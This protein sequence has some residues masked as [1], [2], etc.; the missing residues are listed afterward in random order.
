VLRT[1]RPQA[2]LWEA[3]L[4]AEVLGLPAELATVDRLLDD[5]AFIQPYLPSCPR[6]APAGNTSL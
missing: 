5:P 1:T 4:P 6:T 3:I 2:S